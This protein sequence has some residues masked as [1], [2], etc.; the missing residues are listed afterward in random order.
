MILLAARFSY[1]MIAKDNSRDDLMD[2]YK[3]EYCELLDSMGGE[4]TDENKNMIEQKIAEYDNAEEEVNKIADLY[5]DNKI[6]GT[7][8]HEA[9]LKSMSIREKCY[10]YDLL[11]AQYKYVLED[12]TNHY[13]MYYG[14]WRRFFSSEQDAIILLFL[15]LMMI[16]PIFMR[17]YD[18]DMHRLNKTTLY[19]HD[20]MFYAKFFGGIIYSFLVASLLFGCNLLVYSLRYGL[21]NWSY[22]I[23]SISLFSDFKY[24]INILEMVLYIYFIFIIGACFIAV[25]IMFLSTLMKNSLYCTTI[26]LLLILAPYY[27]I[28]KYT[29]YKKGLPI[30]FIKVNGYIGDLKDEITGEK[31][32]FSV[33]EIL[34]KVAI[35]GI[36]SLIMM[37]FS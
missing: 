21:N 31:I 3:N 5:Y 16:I 32:F 23:Q 24:N 4:L 12:R 37:L 36:L 8:Y 35:F 33:K 26:T 18:N 28:D 2:V 11:K 13:L 19:G 7:E 9:T 20:K 17:E 34:I 22:P 1:G 15:E 30:A 6:S 25:L 27:I 14:G 29:L 10:F